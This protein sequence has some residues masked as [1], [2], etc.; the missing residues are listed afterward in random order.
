MTEPKPKAIYQLHLTLAGI[1]P[2]IWRRFQVYEDTTLPQLHR[3]I[4]ALMNWEE[5]HLHQFTVSGRVYAEPDPDDEMY[6][7]KITDER[8]VRLSKIL[9]FVGVQFEYLYDFGDDWEHDIRLEAILLPEPGVSYPRCV[10]A[11]RNAPPEDCGGPFGYMEYVEALK[12]RMHERHREMRDWRGPFDAEF[13]S[14]DLFNERLGLAAKS[15]R[16]PVLEPIYISPF[17]KSRTRGRTIEIELSE[18]ERDMILNH[19]LADEHLVRDLHASKKGSK[20]RFGWEELDD[21]AGY[22]AAEA[23]QARNKKLQQE[24]R[25]IYDKFVSVL[26]S[27]RP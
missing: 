6:E 4:H 27:K 22:I 8:R 2:P 19:S 25:R 24:W 5:S 10:A 15:T 23:N 7:R 3:Y 14:I 26:D 11:A 12:D 20:F 17:T 13:Y 21:L 1:N 18:R 16:M 9:K